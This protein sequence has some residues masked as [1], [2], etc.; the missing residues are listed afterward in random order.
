MSNFAC[1]IYRYFG[2][3]DEAM[4]AGERA[5]QLIRHLLT[6]SRWWPLFTGKWAA[7]MTRSRYKKSQDTRSSRVP[8]GLAITYEQNEPPGGSDGRNY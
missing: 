5:L 6:A 4:A 2:L 8:F 7:L 1:E 3:I